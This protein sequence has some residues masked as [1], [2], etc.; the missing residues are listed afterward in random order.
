MRH[1][2]RTL[3][4][5]AALLP[6]TLAHAGTNRVYLVPAVKECPGPATCVPREYESTYTFD[7]IILLSPGG[8]YLSTGKK[9]SL[10]LDIRGV[11]DASHALV[12][13]NLTLVILPVRVSLATLGTF[14][15][16]SPFTQNAPVQVPIT[17][18]A[19]RFPYRPSAVAPNGTLVNGGGVEVLDPDGKRLAVIGT[20]A[21]P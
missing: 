3:A 2:L 16:D 1:P 19:T 21:K 12:T 9:P 8:K 18:G 11:R 6:P 17:N 15:D 10:T 5:L 14:P 13:G 4:L 20:Q 7:A